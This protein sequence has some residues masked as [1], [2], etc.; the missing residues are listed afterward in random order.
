MEAQHDAPLAGD[1][2]LVVGGE[3]E[4]HH[5]PR[6]TGRRLDDVRHVALAR[7][8]VEV[9]EPH[10]AEASAWA[11]RS[12][13]VRLAMPS[14]SPQPHGKSNSTSAVPAE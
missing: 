5:R 11:F 14:S 6:R 4:R 10:A 12:K 13:S 1:L 7:R 2:V 8:L 3:Q 9:L